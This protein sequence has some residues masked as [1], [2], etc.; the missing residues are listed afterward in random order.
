MISIRELIVEYGARLGVLR[1][2]DL[3]V[4]DVAESP[5]E[6]ELRPGVLFREVRGGFEKWAH[7]SCPRCHEHIQLPLGGARCWSLRVDWLRRPTLHPSVWQTG[8]C[9]AHFFVTRGILVWVPD[10]HDQ[11]LRQGVNYRV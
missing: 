4:M 5:D 8:S 1:K 11:A 7:F 3:V 9:G 2:P 10:T 6:E